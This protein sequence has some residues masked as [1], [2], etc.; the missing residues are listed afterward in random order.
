M[1]NFYE[2]KNEDPL[3]LVC[4]ICNSEKWHM[5]KKLSMVCHWISL[6]D[7]RLKIKFIYHL[8]RFVFFK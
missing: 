5:D 6:V 2:T 4:N 7:L 1:L 8:W 3:G